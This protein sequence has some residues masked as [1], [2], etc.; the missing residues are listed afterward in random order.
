[1]K[2]KPKVN[3]ETAHIKKRGKKYCV[4]ATIGKRKSE[5]CIAT[6]NDQLA[7]ERYVAKMLYPD[8]ESEF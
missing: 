8:I 3:D 4:Y 1:M 5:F 7:A 2:K 6:F